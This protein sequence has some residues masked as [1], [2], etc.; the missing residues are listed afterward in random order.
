MNLVWLAAVAEKVVV[1]TPRVFQ[2]IGKHGHQVKGTIRVDDLGHFRHRPV[3]PSEQRR[4]KGRWRAE[5][6]AEDV[7]HQN[8]LSFPCVGQSRENRVAIR[9]LD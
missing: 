9:L 8:T 4:S 5:R 7:S 6:V 2:S 3:I 1:V